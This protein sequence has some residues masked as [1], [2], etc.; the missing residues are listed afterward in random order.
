MIEQGSGGLGAVS[1][2]ISESLVE[3][4]L[5]AVPML[6]L[7]FSMRGVARRRGARAQRL[8]LLHLV[9]TLA[10]PGI[11]ILSVSVLFR[12]AYQDGTDTLLQV[13]GILNLLWFVFLVMQVV[14][15]GWALVVGGGRIR[16]HFTA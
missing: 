3:G 8:R 2:G 13:L 11:E 7:N 12:R 10:Y 9:A 5:I 6:I 16:R 1:S 14:F 4:I 15:V